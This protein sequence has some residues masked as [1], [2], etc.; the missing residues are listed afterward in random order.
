MWRSG[1]DADAAEAA[2]LK[3][4]RSTS[5]VSTYKIEHVHCVPISRDVSFGV[6]G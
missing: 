6:R 3:D 4:I 2:L 1:A 5:S